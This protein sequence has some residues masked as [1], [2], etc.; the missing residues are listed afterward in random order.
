MALFVKLSMTG[1]YR[2]WYCFGECQPA[3]ATCGFTTGMSA[4]AHMVTF[5]RRSHTFSLATL[6]FSLPSLCSRALAAGTDARLVKEPA[7]S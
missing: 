3:S 2:H 7:C 6:R 5:H 1:M 4:D